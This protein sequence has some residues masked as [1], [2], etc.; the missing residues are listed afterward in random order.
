MLLREFSGERCKKASVEIGLQFQSL[1]I[2]PKNTKGLIQEINPQFSQPQPH[3]RHISLVNFRLC[4]FDNRPFSVPVHANSLKPVYDAT[5]RPIEPPL[6]PPEAPDLADCDLPNDGFV[7]DERPVS[8]DT[9]QDN[10]CHD[11]D[12]DEP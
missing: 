1:G 4:T 3:C 9:A 5:D 12:R 7:V 11:P 10:P 6:Y 2:H 8:R